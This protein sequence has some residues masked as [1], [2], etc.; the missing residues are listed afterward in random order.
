MEAISKA[1]Y[2]QEAIVKRKKRK[3]SHLTV[4]MAVAMM[5]IWKPGF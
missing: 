2:L 4:A 1:V 5:K 3:G